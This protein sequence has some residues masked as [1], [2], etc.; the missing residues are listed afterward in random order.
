MLDNINDSIECAKE[1]SNLLKGLNCYVNLIPYN[2]VKT[3]DYRSTAHD[4]AEEFFDI[5]CRYI[6]EEIKSL[7]G[8]VLFDTRLEKINI[9]NNTIKNDAP[10]SPHSSHTIEKMKSFW[11]SGTQRYF[12]LDCPIPLPSTPSA[13][14]IA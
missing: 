13:P 12:C 10:K 6:R 1:L 9:K 2:E 8:K 7:G 11:G 14:P 4:A 3:K 5:A